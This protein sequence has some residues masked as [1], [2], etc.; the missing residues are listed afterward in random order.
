M[1][2]NLTPK[3]S[4]QHKLFLTLRNLK[5][6]STVYPNLQF[7]SRRISHGLQTVQLS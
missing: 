7:V 5:F 4:A 2:E 6:F 3:Q 1:P